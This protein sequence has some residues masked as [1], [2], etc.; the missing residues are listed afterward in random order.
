MG[1]FSFA[2]SPRKWCGTNN[3]P[4]D[5]RGLALG[6]PTTWTSLESS[7]FG[8]KSCQI[9]VQQHNAVYLVKYISPSSPTKRKFFGSRPV[10]KGIE[11]NASKLHLNGGKSMKWDCWWTKI[12]HSAWLDSH[13]NTYDSYDESWWIFAIRWSEWCRIFSHHFSHFRNSSH[14]W[15]NTNDIPILL[16]I[17][18]P[19]NQHKNIKTGIF[20]GRRH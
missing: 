16:N 20:A 19:K 2:K 14:L 5:W 3:P 11:I 9:P 1:Y 4:S 18:D 10:F 15:K 7:I 17:P 8:H 13:K 12:Q 6:Y